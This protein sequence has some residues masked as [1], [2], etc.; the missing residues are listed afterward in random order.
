MRLFFWLSILLLFLA[1]LSLAQGIKGDFTIKLTQGNS[2]CRL[3]LYKNNTYLYKYSNIDLD[4]YSTLD[5]G[6]Y[7]IKEGAITF[8]SCKAS[9]ED[10]G[11]SKKHYFIKEI[12]LKRQQG[13][14]DYPNYQRK[15]LFKNKFIVLMYSKNDSVTYSTNPIDYVIY[16]KLS[17]DTSLKT[18][19][20]KHILP[21]YNYHSSEL[22]SLNWKLLYSS[23][24]LQILALHNSFGD[25]NSVYYLIDNQIYYTCYQRNIKYH[26]PILDII[27]SK[28]LLNRKEKKEL[29]KKIELALFCD[30][31]SERLFN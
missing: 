18:W 19:I 17:P 16:K 25:L 31:H 27:T 29:L 22:D 21:T 4:S 11:F 3:Y 5:S 8:S 23:K 28:G 24:T 7:K 9:S 2:I 10:V 30:N 1:N 26:M 15:T 6:I 14:N 20:S 13:L 12:K